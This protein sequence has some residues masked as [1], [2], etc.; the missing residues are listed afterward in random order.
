MI[1]L[2]FSYLLFMLVY[3]IILIQWI[4]STALPATYLM[5]FAVSFFLKMTSFHHVCA[6]NRYLVQRVNQVRVKNKDISTEELASMFNVS[7][8][9]FKIAM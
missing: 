9:T 2:E 1:I 3:P 5:L 8:H 7:E 6:D 4:E